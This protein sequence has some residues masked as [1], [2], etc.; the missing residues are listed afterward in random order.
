MARKTLHDQFLLV[1]P[2]QQLLQLFSSCRPYLSYS[3]LHLVAKTHHTL[4]C[5]TALAHDVHWKWKAFALALC[6]RSSLAWSSSL[7]RGLLQQLWE[8]QALLLSIRAP[9]LWISQ[10]FPILDLEKKSLTKWFYLTYIF[11]D[12]CPFHQINWKKDSDPFPHFCIPVPK[13][14]LV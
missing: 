12:F 6:M 5:L 14:F 4:C 10:N 7:P 13:R 9:C 3:G 2:P 1:F 8:G 11:I